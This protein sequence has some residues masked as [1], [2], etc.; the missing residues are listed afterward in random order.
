MREL[1][2]KASVREED[3]E[4]ETVE[5]LVVENYIYKF[6]TIISNYYFFE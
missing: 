2:N 4:E 5:L 3:S 1:E 6:G